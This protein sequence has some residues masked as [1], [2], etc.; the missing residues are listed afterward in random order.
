MQLLS[1][2]F[3]VLFTDG[4]TAVER[5]HMTLF[6]SIEVPK[7]DEEKEIERKARA[8]RARETRRSTQVTDDDI[9]LLPCVLMSHVPSRIEQ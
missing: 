9:V 7:R 2:S 3:P 1:R 4:I 8:K 5:L 6:R